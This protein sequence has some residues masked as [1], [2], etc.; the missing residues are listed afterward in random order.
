MKIHE[1][2]K[3]MLDK[4]MW[5]SCANCGNYNKYHKICELVKVKP[6]IETVILSCSSWEEDI[7]F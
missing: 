6:P 1:I 3:E 4:N 5:R 2:Q 7:P